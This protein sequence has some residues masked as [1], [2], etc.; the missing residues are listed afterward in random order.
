AARHARI[1]RAG[2]GAVPRLGRGG[3]LLP[4]VGGGS[5][6][7]EFEPLGRRLEARWR[8]IGE[9]I[10]VLRLAWTGEPFT[11][12]GRRCRVTP[13]PE[14]PPP[15]LLGGGTKAAARRAAHVADGWFPPLEPKLWTP[16]RDECLA[17]AKPDPPP[18]P[19]P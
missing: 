8:A 15:I 19:P 14:P 7:W 18:H 4:G 13:R 1:R 10:E 3:R 6:P 5:R 17:L 11:W 2:D 9:A 16:Y 12:Q